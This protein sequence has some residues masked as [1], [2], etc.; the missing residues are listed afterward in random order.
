MSSISR[1]VRSSPFD[2]PPVV[3][4]TITRAYGE[5]GRAYHNLRHL[6]EMAEAY[7]LV[8][9]SVGWAGPKEVFAALLFHD[10]VYLPGQTQNEEQSAQL[11]ESVLAAALPPA[12]VDLARVSELIRLTARHGHLVSARL[13]RD[14][15]LFLD[16]DMAI[17]GA[18][19]ER[20]DEYERAI[21]EE[22]ARRVGPTE[23]AAGRRAFLERLL[24]A[25]HL[26]LSALFRES[27]E[28]A[29]RDNLFRALSACR[30]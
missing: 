27:L 2:C 26:Y 21:A 14:T 24:A 11:A 8:Q 13:D 20:Y 4:E 16:C 3:L 9:R 29:A 7:D 23:Y 12:S 28:S 30:T 22:Y 17:L 25:D 15:Q 1:L 18:T 19:D 10:A 5:P 6:E